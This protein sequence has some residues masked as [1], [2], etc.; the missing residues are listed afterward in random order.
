MTTDVLDGEPRGLVGRVRGILLRPQSEWLRIASE[1]RA[2]LIGP[3]VAPLAI[4]AAL[5]GLVADIAYARF[6]I[7]PALA[8]KGVAA[9][10]Y[11][12][13]AIVGV[14]L[15]AA[16]IGLLLRRFGGEADGW[17]AKQLA[18]YAATP[19][20]VAAIGAVAPPIAGIVAAAGV[21]YAL[22]LLAVGVPRLAPLPDADNNVPRFTLTFSVVAIGL[23]ALAAAFIGPLVSA[24]REALLGAIETVVSAPPAPVV[25][26]R[27]AVELAIDRLAQSDG[28]HVLVDPARLEEQF[29]D[30][31]P[32]GFGRQSVTIAQAGGVS[33]ADAVY[34]KESARLRVSVIQFTSSIDPAAA[35][36]MLRVTPDGQQ[37]NG[38]TRTQS[39]DGRLFSEEVA[40][41][42]SRYVVIGRGIVMIAEGQATMDQARAAI[43]TIDLQRLEA[44]FGR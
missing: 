41:D 25:A 38:Y 20:L 44:A 7:G 18:V 16:V 33:R 30:S 6:A 37:E 35:A 40:G 3:Y 39:I 26:R 21:V 14:L 23:A 13:F 4:G 29:P 32:S 17:R 12:L 42:T 31:L 15:A 8:W 1:E 43:E 10:L 9:A 19:V 11:V 36:T 34:V 22:V 27:S 5:I 2:P 24:G 28:A